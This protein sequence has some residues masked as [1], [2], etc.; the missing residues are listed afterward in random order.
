MVILGPVDQVYA[1]S[2]EPI[3]AFES[4]LVELDHKVWESIFCGIS[5]P[6]VILLSAII[7]EVCSPFSGLLSGVNDKC[8][9]ISHCEEFS[10]SPFGNRST[11]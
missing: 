7:P 3:V 4:V 6:M 5:I 11:S 9:L 2:G 10:K 1:P 8:S